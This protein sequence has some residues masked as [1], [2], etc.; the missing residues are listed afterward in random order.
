M[1]TLTTIVPVFIACLTGTSLTNNVQK[2]TLRN[3]VLFMIVLLE[4]IVIN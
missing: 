2:I 3:K 4:S 1:A